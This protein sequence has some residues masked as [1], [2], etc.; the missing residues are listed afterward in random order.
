MSMDD[1]DCNDIAF[2]RNMIDVSTLPK[3]CSAFVFNT[4]IVSLLYI[5]VHL[6]SPCYR[7]VYHGHNIRGLRRVLHTW[8]TLC[9]IAKY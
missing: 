4:I 2:V 9:S 7:M 3:S 8:Y 5:S 1:T 6:R